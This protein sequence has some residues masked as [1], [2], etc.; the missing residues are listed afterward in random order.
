MILEEKLNKFKE[1]QYENEKKTLSNVVEKLIKQ[2]E[3]KDL[4]LQ[5][6]GK[7]QKEKRNFWEEKKNHFLEM[8]RKI[9]KEDNE[10]LSNVKEKLQKIENNLDSKKVIFFFL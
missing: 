10:K 5:K 3:K 2:E 4:I 9:K 6:I 1:S 7:I 8:K